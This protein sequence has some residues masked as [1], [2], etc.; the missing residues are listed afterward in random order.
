M[1]MNSDARYVLA[2]DQ[3]TTNTKALLVNG[4]GEVVARASRPFK[5][6]YPHP[7]W[8]QQDPAEI[9]QS[10]QE[11]IDNCL[12]SVGALNLAA[13]AISNQRESVTAWD[14][15]TGEPLGPVITTS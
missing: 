1:A 15:R 9:W 8:V 13:V 4:A 3:G 11:V 14:R 2:I 7:A 6:T 5:Q 12:T 10:V